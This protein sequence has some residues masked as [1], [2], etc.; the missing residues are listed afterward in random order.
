MKLLKSSEKKNTNTEEVNHYMMIHCIIEIY[1]VEI[2]IP[3]YW[4]FFNSNK[5][6]FKKV[7]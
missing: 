6:T 1:Q 3:N 4:S 5:C 7:Q 2:E